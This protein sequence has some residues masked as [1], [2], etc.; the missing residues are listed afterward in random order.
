MEKAS[1]L[2]RVYGFTLCNQRGFLLSVPYL[3]G[4]FDYARLIST[5]NSRRYSLMIGR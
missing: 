3:P 4:R 5:G 2:N 1:Q